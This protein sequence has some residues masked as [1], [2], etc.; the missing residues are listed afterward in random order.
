MRKARTLIKR[1]DAA[2]RALAEAVSVDEVKDIRD[3]A[4]A[5]KVYA[6]QA[7][8]RRMIDDA[9]QLQMRAERRAGELLREMEKNKGGA[10]KGI[11]R[12][13]VNNAVAPN[14]RILPVK[15]SDLGIT[16]TQ[17]SRWQ[18]LASLTDE[19]FEQKV[20]ER[21][22]ADNAAS[23]KVVRSIIV[24]RAETA[25]SKAE[26]EFTVPEWN[27]LSAAE[28]EKYLD[29]EK[30]PSNA[31]LNPHDGDG[32]DYAQISYSTI[33]GCKH[34]CQI[35]CWAND[36][37]QR[38]PKI[39]PHGFNNPAFRPR[40]LSAPGNTSVPAEAAIDGRFKNVSSNFMSDMF[41]AWI[42]ADWIEATLAVERADPRW[43]FLHLTKFPGRLLEFEFSPNMW[44]GTSVDL[45]QRVE[46]VERVFA[47][48]REKYP[49]LVLW[50]S[51][52]PFLE[53]LKFQC[54]KL[55]N[56]I[57]IGGAAKSMRTPEWRP[58]HRWIM[59]LIE[60]VDKQTGSRC[61]IFEKT[62]LYGN[63]ILEL[64]GGLLVPPDYE[65][66]APDIFDYLNPKQRKLL[67]DGT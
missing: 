61:K 48:L 30:F 9:T 54:L 10:E 1:Y 66:V 58:P 29:P 40:M 19:G 2:I 24:P 32:T 6:E 36:Q 20:A 42:P 31:K 27:K 34:P 15:L 56:F 17:S 13:G 52:E 28:R 67:G 49:D 35:Y 59:D 8:D 16:K 3:K 65:Q 55:F 53:A 44:I 33:A 47:K 57:A 43:N 12:R 60:Q 4:L 64:P 38:F 25:A 41:G 46:N 62:N 5:M 50:L 45:Q 23:A 51:I 22:E 37:T 26:V 11:G 14:D 39:Y 7:K 21:I 18:R 63:R